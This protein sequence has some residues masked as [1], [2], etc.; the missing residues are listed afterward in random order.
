MKYAWCV[1]RRVVTSDH[2]YIGLANTPPLMTRLIKVEQIE[3][4]LALETAWTK[5]KLRYFFPRSAST[6]FRPSLA[7]Y[8][9]END[10]C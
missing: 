6:I 1:V 9:S 10:S 8:S 7:S 3:V 4:I 2:L 5:W